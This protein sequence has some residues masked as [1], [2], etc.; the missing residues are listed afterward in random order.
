MNVIESRESLGCIQGTHS[1]RE[2]SYIAQHETTLEVPA[3]CQKKKGERKSVKSE[4]LRCHNPGAAVPNFAA[5]FGKLM[6]HSCW[7]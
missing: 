2:S 7:L 1:I 4:G 3:A 6:A 5:R